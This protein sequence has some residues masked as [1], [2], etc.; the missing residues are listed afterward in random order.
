MLFR[1]DGGGRRSIF[2]P[3]ALFTR[4]VTAI[5]TPG[6]FN[7]DPGPDPKL[8]DDDEAFPPSPPSSEE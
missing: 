6:G 8:D 7:G 5:P 1:L 2:S 4:L 3:N